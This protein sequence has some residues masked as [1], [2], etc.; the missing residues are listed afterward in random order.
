VA[1]AMEHVDA[2]PMEGFNAKALDEI[3][4]LNEKGLKSV[5]IMTL[6]YR[7]QEKDPLVNAKKV[8]RPHEEFF[9]TV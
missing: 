9:I 8:R 5:V 2:T 4:S 7:D 1:A 3:L 6:G